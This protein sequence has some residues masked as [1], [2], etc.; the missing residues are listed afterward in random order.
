MKKP[1][2]LIVLLFIGL[3]S[4]SQSNDYIEMSREVIKVGTK[5][6][7]GSVL[8]LTDA[9]K[10]AFWEMYSEYEAENYKVQN[11]RIAIIKDFADNFENLTDEK[12]S[13]LVAQSFGYKEDVL[14]LKKKYYK[15]ATKIIPATEAAKFI[16][17]LNK[18]DDL[19]NAELA[20]EIP[21]L[22]TD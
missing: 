7:I 13:T 19:I 15:K 8:N 3:A 14:K 4:Y 16:Q 9:Q 21:M 17:A 22:K 20:L 5:D 6:A 2:L 18:I 10:T 1:L 11:K 12:A